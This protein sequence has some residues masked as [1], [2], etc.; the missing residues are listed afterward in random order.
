[1]EVLPAREGPERDDEA[2]G[3]PSW[4]WLVVVVAVISVFLGLVIYFLL[5]DR[6]FGQATQPIHTASAPVVQKP[7]GPRKWYV[8]RN[9][10]EGIDFTSITAALQGA[11]PGDT[12]VITDRQEYHEALSLSSQTSSRGFNSVTIVADVGD[13]GKRARLIPPRTHRPVTP[14]V[15]IENVQGLKI[16]GL[17]VDGEDAVQTTMSIQGACPGLI[18]E[19]VRIEGFQ[20]QGIV[21]D[22]LTGTGRREVLFDRVFVRQNVPQPAQACLQ[23]LG[24]ACDGLQLKQCRFQGLCEATIR[25]GAPIQRFLM[26]QCKLSGGKGHALLWS[27]AIPANQRMN[28]TIQQNTFWD[29]QTGMAIEVPVTAGDIYFTIRNNVFYQ[30]KS[31]LHVDAA[32][33]KM[34]PEALT[35]GV[36]GLGNVYDTQ[37]SQPGVA[38]QIAK[39]GCKGLAF[40]LSTSPTP[41]QDFLRVPAGS[42][43]L[44]AGERKDPVGATD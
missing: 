24:A 10:L 23:I 20:R 44:T 9:K 36:A 7:T 33:T 6:S 17:L 27:D 16:V 8:A 19:N 32:K 40:S 11:G 12:I 30:V 35:G 5:R 43:L 25:F 39:F 22:G 26:E 3:I 41:P 4:V 34:K 42:P 38:G 21:I 37:S 2:G 18:L 1:M 31:L 15:S 14:L 29:Y 28:A 13:D